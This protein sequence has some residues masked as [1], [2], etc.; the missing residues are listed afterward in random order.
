MK[1]V[2]NTWNV[3]FSQSTNQQGRSN[4]NQP[5]TP[6]RIQ[7]EFTPALSDPRKHDFDF[8]HPPPPGHFCTICELFSL[9]WRVQFE[10]APLPPDP[11]SVPGHT[12]LPS[13]QITQGEGSKFCREQ[14]CEDLKFLQ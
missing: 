4:P 7:G 13:V 11:G 12:H 1:R 3:V 14:E 6:G 2:L 10:I 9:C 5:D 8:L